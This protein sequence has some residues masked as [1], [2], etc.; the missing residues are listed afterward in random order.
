MMKPMKHN[1]N[2]NDIF[3]KAALQLADGT[4]KD[5][6]FF[7]QLVILSGKTV[8]EI[9]DFAEILKKSRSKRNA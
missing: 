7:K 6:P 5:N 2:R 1:V 8:E 4:P 3:Q 9:E